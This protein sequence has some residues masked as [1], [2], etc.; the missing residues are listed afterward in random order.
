M[1]NI[2]CLVARNGQKE[3][4]EAVF[5]AAALFDNNYDFDLNGP[6]APHNFVELDLKLD[7]QR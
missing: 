6:W 5:Q 2:N 7:S 3:F 4:E 1:A